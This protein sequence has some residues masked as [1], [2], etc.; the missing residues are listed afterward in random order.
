M[1]L[2]EKGRE[3][4]SENP[5]K[6]R[7]RDNDRRGRRKGKEHLRKTVP[8]RRSAEP[9]APSQP[10][11]SPACVLCHGYQ[12]GLPVQPVNVFFSSRDELGTNVSQSVSWTINVICPGT[13]KYT[14]GCEPGNTEP[15]G[16][17]VRARARQKAL[18]CSFNSPE[19]FYLSS[20]PEPNITRWS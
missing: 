12:T 17:N 4:E 18:L 19:N 15:H 16:L 14:Q 3:T 2:W 8:E 7:L 10:S 5:R 1:C 13:H 6:E 20:L 11:S 9:A